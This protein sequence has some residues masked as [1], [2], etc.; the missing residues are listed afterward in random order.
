LTQQQGA[1][2]VLVLVLVHSLLELVQVP[3]QLQPALAQQLPVLL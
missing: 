2:L 3:Q 1:Q